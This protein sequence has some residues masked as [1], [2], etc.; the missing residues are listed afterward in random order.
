MTTY[1]WASLGAVIT[2]G[3]ETLTINENQS[4]WGDF[5]VECGQ[6]HKITERIMQI[7][8]KTNKR[9]IS[10]TTQLMYAPSTS[11]SGEEAEHFFMKPSIRA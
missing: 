3:H 5:Q 11:A 2:V 1:V 10:C 4:I 8:P 9:Y 7:T 6:L